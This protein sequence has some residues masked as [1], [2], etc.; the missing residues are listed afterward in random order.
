PSTL[1]SR[2]PSSTTSIRRLGSQTCSPDCRI[3]P[4]S[5]LLIY[6]PGIGAHKI[7]PLKLLDRAARSPGATTPWPSPD[8]YPRNIDY[9]HRPITLAGD[10]Q[11]V[12]MECHVHGLAAHLDCRLLA[13]RRVHELA[14]RRAAGSARPGRQPSD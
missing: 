5:G 2:P 1:S 14:P 12:A 11:L 9:M 10:E 7:S 3:I 13:K 8:A 6:C 4:P